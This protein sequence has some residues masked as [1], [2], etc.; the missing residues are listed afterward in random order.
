MRSLSKIYKT[1]PLKTLKVQLYLL[2]VPDASV[3]ERNV[4]L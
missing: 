2:V 1:Q 4:I 3:P